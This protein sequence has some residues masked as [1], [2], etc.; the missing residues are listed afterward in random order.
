[1]PATSIRFRLYETMKAVVLFSALTHLLILFTY[2]IL[3]REW[4]QL[5]YFNIIDIDLFFNN[6]AQGAVSQILSVIL[7]LLLIVGVFIFK[8]KR[9]HR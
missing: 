2:V 6:A 3:R 5:N 1:M 7:F 8:T 4:G 9:S